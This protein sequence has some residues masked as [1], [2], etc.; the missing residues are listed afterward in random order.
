MGLGGMDTMLANRNCRMGF[1]NGAAVAT[2]DN[3]ALCLNHFLSRCY[4]KLEKLEPRG[5][6]FSSEP[7]DLTSM[8]AFI[9][10]CSRKALDISLHSQ[11]LTNLQ[12]GRLLDILLWAGELFLLLRAPRLTLAQSIASSDEHFAAS[13]ASP[14]F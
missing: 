3:Q 9:E 11:S 8:R 1:C 6:K 12:R 14:N 5:R 13:A 4:E 7:V 2:L 10:E